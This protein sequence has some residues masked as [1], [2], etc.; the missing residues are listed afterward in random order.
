VGGILGLITLITTVSLSFNYVD[1]DQIALVQNRFGTVDLSEVY[2]HQRRFLL[3]SKSLITFP[4]TYTAVDFVTPVF[5]PDGLQFDLRVLFYYRLTPQG[6]ARTYSRYSRNYDV[7]VRS[8]VVTELKNLAPSF[9]LDDYIARRPAIEANMSAILAAALESDVGV[10]MPREFFRLMSLTLPPT[11]LSTS[12][13]SAIQLQLNE[14]QQLQQLVSVIEAETIQ[15]VAAVH[16]EAESLVSFAQTRA[17]AIVANAQQGADALQAAAR[18]LGL[19]AF[20][21][22]LNVTDADTKMLLVTKLARLDADA[23]T[24]VSTTSP[25][26]ATASVLVNVP[27]L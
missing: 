13:A 7:R 23:P 26:G 22:A 3:L 18:G 5:L 16:A 11:V 19:H 20:F 27:K 6:L 17:A 14:V 25:T 4:S 2:E 9:A 15:K 1:Y 12:L 8:K 10:A 21:A 24:V